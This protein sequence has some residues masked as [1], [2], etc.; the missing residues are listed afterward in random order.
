M[1]DQKAINLAPTKDQ[2][3]LLSVLREHKSLVM[4]TNVQSGKS[5]AMLLHSINAT[6]NSIPRKRLESKSS[7]SGSISHLI[8]VPNNSLLLKYKDWAKDLI[9]E[10]EPNCVATH[11]EYSGEESRVVRSPLNIQI[12]DDKYNSCQISTGPKSE[13]KFMPQIVI[14]NSKAFHKSFRG[15]KHLPNPKDYLN[16][17]FIGVDEADFL[18]SGSL[19][20]D[21]NFNVTTSGKKKKFVLCLSESIKKLKTL[22]LDS[23]KIAPKRKFTPIQFCFLFHSQHPFQNIFLKMANGQKATENEERPLSSVMKEY[24][25]TKNQVSSSSFDPK[26]AVVEK[27]IRMNDE[28]YKVSKEEQTLVSIDEFERKHFYKTELNGQVLKRVNLAITETYKDGKSVVTRP[29]DPV[30]NLPERQDYIPYFSK[31]AKEFNYQINNTFKQYLRDKITMEFS[32]ISQTN[33]RDQVYKLVEHTLKRFRE[34]FDNKDPILFI[35]PSQVDFN[36]LSKKLNSESKAKEAIVCYSKFHD[37]SKVED[38]A[39]VPLIGKDITNY[40][41]RTL[42]DFF[43]RQKDKDPNSTI[44]NLLYPSNELPGMDF[45]GIKNTII[46]GTPLL[47]PQYACASWEKSTKDNL[48][49]CISG[50]EAPYNDMFYYYLLKLQMDQDRDDRNILLVQDTYFEPHKLP[51][52]SMNGVVQQDINRLRELMLLNDISSL[53]NH[54]EFEDPVDKMK[55]ELDY[56]SYTLS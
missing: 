14:M 12:I 51:M 20:S 33:R 24:N 8:L 44:Y 46:F 34:I 9:K 18:I 52:K 49:N 5:F 45:A 55:A 40:S 6:L 17:K 21:F 37:I 26:M 31:Y 39:K 11:M 28:E 54:V 27:L 16:C 3:N 32:K 41:S 13:S 15:S 2:S 47:Y 50:I 43:S 36:Y 7:G 10:I 23:F 30:A 48:I 4:K 1:F 35:M 38:P 19:A 53:V 56:E 22:Q 25:L 42:Q 29:I